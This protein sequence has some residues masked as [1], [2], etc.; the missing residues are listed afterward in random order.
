[1]CDAS[2]YTIG[3]MLGQRID[4]KP[5]V[6]YYASHTLNDAQLNYTVTEKEFLVVVFGF[7]KF[8]SYL[9]GSHVIVYIGHSALKHLLSKKDARPRL[10]RWI[11]LLQ[12]FDCEIK[13]KKGSEN[14]VADHLSR[15]LSES[16]S[17]VSGCFPD[18]QLYAVHPDPWYA[19]IV[20]Y[21]VAGRIPEVW[22]KNDK[23]RFFHLVKFFVWDDP[24][25]FKY[26]SDQVFRRCIPD[27][28]IRS[29]LSF[30]HDQACGGHFSGKKTAAKIL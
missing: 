16:E 1:M 3:V 19:D 21:L 29:V 4:K 14:F 17:S 26:C 13:D 11:L 12:E 22:T 18:E 10:I 23:D 8:R 24:Y 6:I 27:H 5:Y 30:C 28:E 7:E 2:D 9:I 25:L 15:I 20:N